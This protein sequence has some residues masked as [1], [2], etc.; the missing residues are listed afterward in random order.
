MR[1]ARKQCMRGV[2]KAVHGGLAKGR[3]CMRRARK[4]VYER[5]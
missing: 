2:M 3:Q 4:A 1:G 5:G